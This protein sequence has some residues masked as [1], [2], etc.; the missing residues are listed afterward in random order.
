M[1]E[2]RSEDGR[3]TLYA[4]GRVYRLTL[5]GRVQ[6]S[7][8][9]RAILAACAQTKLTLSDLLSA[10]RL[11]HRAPKRV[12]LPE[13]LFV[14]AVAKLL[15]RGRLSV[16][17][18]DGSLCVGG[19]PSPE[20]D[21]ANSVDVEV[22]RDDATGTIWPLDS[23]GAPRVRTAASRDQIRR[24]GPV[25]GVDLMR[26]S[27][28]RIIEELRLR[29]PGAVPDVASEVLGRQMAQQFEFLKIEAVEREDGRLAV[30]SLVPWRLRAAWAR[31]S[32]PGI[33]LAPRDSIRVEATPEPPSWNRSFDRWVAAIDSNEETGPAQSELLSL[34][35]RRLYPRLVRSTDIFE[36]VPSTRHQTYMGA[37]PNSAGHLRALMKEVPAGLAIKVDSTEA[38][39]AV[40]SHTL[41]LGGSFNPQH[42]GSHSFKVMGWVAVTAF[43]RAAIGEEV[44]IS[45]EPDS[46]TVSR[47]RNAI[48]GAARSM[49][50]ELARRVPI[51]VDVGHPVIWL[52]TDDAEFLA[53]SIEWT[54]IALSPK[55]DRPP[56]W[57]R[58]ASGEPTVGLYCTTPTEPTSPPD[59]WISNTGGWVLVGYW[60]IGY[61]GCRQSAELGSTLRDMIGDWELQALE[62]DAPTVAPSPPNHNPSPLSKP[63]PPIGAPKPTPTNEPNP[64]NAPSPLQ[65]D[66]TSSKA[67]VAKAPGAPSVAPGPENIVRSILAQLGQTPVE[68]DWQLEYDRLFKAI[69]K[70]DF[71]SKNDR[72]AKLLVAL[73]AARVNALQEGWPKPLPNLIKAL[74]GFTKKTQIGLIH[75]LSR[76]HTS[77]SWLEE[78]HSAEQ[79]LVELFEPKGP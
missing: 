4:R 46:P 61:F 28:A 53:A 25:L 21:A 6:E 75:G 22:W 2:E 37:G 18:S 69:G 35:D 19:T 47:L 64:P 15:E 67:P 33:E 56:A 11:D 58:N 1:T 73:L 76:Q 29:M 72:G 68:G 31:V 54:I 42:K 71:V 3:R 12:P 26:A 39:V 24:S 65:S 30:T 7:W 16:K 20:L 57:I 66:V 44:A 10:A 74:I 32:L 45:S 36:S 77:Q 34:L 13:G 70:L 5:S 14:D 52:S 79:A 60:S 8:L 38:F 55:L 48:D 41:F 17:P 40:D 59:V 63:V 49:D 50:P 9:E 51:E 23:V 43:L 27:S 78:A 62:T